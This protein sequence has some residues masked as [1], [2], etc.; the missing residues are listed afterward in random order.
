MAEITVQKENKYM[1]SHMFRVAAI[2]NINW[3]GSIVRA[4]IDLEILPHGIILKD[5]LLKEGQYGWFLSSPSKKLK[6]PFT[7]KEGV[8]KHYMDL[9]FFPKAIR[10]EL[11]KVCVESYDPSGNYGMDTTTTPHPLTD[12]AKEMFVDDGMP[13]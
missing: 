3:E 8:E 11:N 7:T 4:S 6:E 1:T 10:E 5:C 2:R 9:A 12:K 13:Q